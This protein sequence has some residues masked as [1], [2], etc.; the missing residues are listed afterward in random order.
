MDLTFQR[1]SADSSSMTK[2]QDRDAIYVKRQFDTEIIVLCVRWYITYRLRYRDLVA[3][4]AE[5]GATFHHSHS[6][7]PKS[8]HPRF[9]DS[10]LNACFVSDAERLIDGSRACLWIHGHTHDTFDYFLNGTRV[11]CNPRGDAKQ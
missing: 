10:L 4:M 6:P 8:I 7:S 11:G 5:R 1:S 9:A 2:R 3:M